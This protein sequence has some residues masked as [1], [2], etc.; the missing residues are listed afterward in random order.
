MLCIRYILLLYAI[1]I[2]LIANKPPQF[3]TSPAAAAS[4]VYIV[5]SYIIFMLH[6][7]NNN[8]NIMFTYFIIIFFAYTRMYDLSGSVPVFRFAF[9]YALLSYYHYIVVRRLRKANNSAHYIDLRPFLHFSYPYH[10]SLG[11]LSPNTPPTHKS[12]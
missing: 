5:V 4:Y 1:C 7:Y 11:L 2:G 8:N 12:S 3:G 9:I 6:T 10:P